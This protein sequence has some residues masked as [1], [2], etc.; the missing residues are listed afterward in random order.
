L[1]LKLKKEL[2]KLDLNNLK[3][4]FAHG[5]FHY[6]NIFITNNKK[7]KFIDF[8]NVVYNEY[9]DFDVLYLLVMIEAKLGLSNNTNIYDNIIPAI[10]EKADLKPI[11]NIYKMAVS[12]NPRFCR[13][14]L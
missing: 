1:K 2:F 10:N 9:F 11:Y 7:I 12:I 4:G 5:D 3:W 13:D 6:N 8:E 14:K